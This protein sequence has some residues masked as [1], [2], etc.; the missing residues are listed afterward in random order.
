MDRFLNFTNCT[1]GEDSRTMFRLTLLT[2]ALVAGLIATKQ[3]VF[4]PADAIAPLATCLALS[5][6]AIFYRVYRPEPGFVL[7]LKALVALVAFSAV[8]SM[9]VYCLAIAGRPLGDTTLAAVDAALGLSAADLVE[10]TSARPVLALVMRLVYFSIIP[11][12]I[13]AIVW[14][15]FSNQRAS[16]D[17]FLVRFMLGGLISAIAFYLLPAKGTCESYALA[18]PSH[19]EKILEHL[20]SLR[21]GGR[22]LITWRDAEGLITFPSF[23]TIWAVL[24]IAA[25][26]RR[27]W[28]FYPV[29]LTNVA[30][31]ISTVTTGMHY[32]ADVIAGLVVCAVL[33]PATKDS[34]ACLTEAQ[35]K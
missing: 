23:H 14:L 1:L 24:L 26:W 17:K 13:F 6:V 11:Q 28:I 30:V 21:H 2:G 34:A 29:A 31:V 32:F 7:C 10:W 35:A 25:F 33:I 4:P 18:V 16:L 3:L 9:L 12:T 5:S 27:G 15:G 19:Y 8:F 22:T 20:D